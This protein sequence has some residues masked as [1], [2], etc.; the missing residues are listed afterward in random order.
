MIE[1]HNSW[2]RITETAT[3]VGGEGGRGGVV[4]I[5]VVVVVLGWWGSLLL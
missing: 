3:C 5:M 1:S 2:A 4:A